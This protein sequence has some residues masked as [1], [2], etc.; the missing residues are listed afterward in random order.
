MERTLYH[1]LNDE[2]EL[3]STERTWFDEKATTTITTAERREEKTK[4]QQRKVSGARTIEP[5]RLH[6]TTCVHMY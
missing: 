3:Q 5:Y 6:F 1:N 4:T 2:I